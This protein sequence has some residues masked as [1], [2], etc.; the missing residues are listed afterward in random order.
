MLWQGVTPEATGHSVA[1]LLL[2]QQVWKCPSI[3]SKSLCFG[4]KQ[5][6]F[7]CQPCTEFF[8]NPRANELWVLW[9]IAAP[10]SW[11]KKPWT[12]GKL[13]LAAAPLA[14]HRG[15]WWDGPSVPR[16]SSKD[17]L[18]DSLVH[19]HRW[20]PEPGQ[21]YGKHRLENGGEEYL[22]DRINGNW[23][24]ILKWGKIRKKEESSLTFRSLT[25]VIGKE[26]W[27]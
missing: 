7:G 23:W 17:S 16:K 3:R 10:F 25:W 24:L 4:A 5:S 11:K 20:W 27:L 18:L 22:E 6:E 13:S 19:F 1:L 21:R 8:G 15:Q 26:W 9:A 2:W 14:G 12:F